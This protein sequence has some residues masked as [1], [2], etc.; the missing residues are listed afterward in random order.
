[1]LVLLKDMTNQHGHKVGISIGTRSTGIAL[2]QHGFLKDYKVLVFKK[3]W[4]KEKLSTILKKLSSLV[5]LPGCM[6]AVKV[7]RHVYFSRELKELICA[8]EQF[9]KDND[10]QY[11]FL[12]L[13]DLKEHCF[14]DLK[15]NKRA[16][17]K[18]MGTKYPQLFLK[19]QLETKSKHAY[20]I[21]L[22]EATIAA[23]IISN[24]DVH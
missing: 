15:A 24:K 20:Y 23:E 18:C 11:R 19:Y 14:P 7:P 22:F 4:S 5:T 21:K 2:L 1:L 3:R 8:I 13:S 6:V 10:V 12:T 16:L 9:L 17:S